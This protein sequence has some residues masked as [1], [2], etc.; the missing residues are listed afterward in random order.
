MIELREFAVGDA[1]PY[2]VSLQG[3]SVL[4]LLG[5]H[6]AAATRLLEALAGARRHKGR[7]RIAGRD[8][9]ASDVAYAPEEVEQ[10]LFGRTA[11]E[12][13]GPGGEAFARRLGAAHLLDRPPQELSS[14][15]RRRLALAAV[16]GSGR[17]LLLFDRPTAGLDPDGQAM[18]WQAAAAHPGAV[19]LSLGSPAEARYCTAL[20]A[21]P[22]EGRPWPG[23]TLGADRQRQVR[24]PPDGAS[25]IAWTLGLAAGPGTLAREVAAWRARRRQR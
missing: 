18:F 5:V 19:V 2:R 12:A 11:A 7:I 23:G 20:L 4:G 9:K 1:G 14:G 21:V 22:G 17:P 8:A 16:F 15:E 6:G 3:R 13:V 25:D 10:V 24:W